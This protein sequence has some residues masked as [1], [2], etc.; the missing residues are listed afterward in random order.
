MVPDLESLR[1]FDAAATHLNFRVAAGAVALSPAAFGDRIKRLEQQLDVSL[2]A[3]TTRRVTLTAAGQ[4]LVTQARRALE[5]AERCHQVVHERPDAVPFELTVGTR[6]ELGLSWLTPSLKQLRASRAERTLHLVFGDSPD[7]LARV[8]NGLLDCAVTSVRLATSGIAYEVLHPERY[9]FVG[10]ASLLR[11]HPLTKAAHA[12][13]HVLVDASP[14]LPL[15]RYLLD[16]T[17]RRDT[18]GF[19]NAEYLGTIG[20][21]RLRILQG[22]GVAV[23]PEYFVERDLKSRRLKRLLPRVV[24]QE[25][26]FRLVWRAGHPREPE[27]RALAKDLLRIPLR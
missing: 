6:F 20:A 5:E 7:L 16:A 14:E 21:I 1:C 27:L 26:A 10:A 2:F 3:R 11:K 19:R 4:R 18:W 13:H 17:G 22:S 9:V 15:F 25:D 8:R 12:A 23:L 24:L